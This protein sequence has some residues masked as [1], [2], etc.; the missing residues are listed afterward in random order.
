MK[1]KKSVM[2]RRAAIQS[3]LG[4]AAGLTGLSQ[5]E[6][7]T[8]TARP[9]AAPAHPVV[10]TASGKIEGYSNRGVSAFLGVP[11]GAS[12][13][14]PNRFLPLRKPEP[15]AGVRDCLN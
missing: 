14:G 1:S 2:G 4:A 8:K 10:E 15:W 7:A 3:A 5:A 13:W 9:S 6:A 12:T 11:Y